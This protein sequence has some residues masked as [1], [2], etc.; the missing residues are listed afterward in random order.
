MAVPNNIHMAGWFMDS[1]R[2]GQMGLSII[3]GHVDGRRET[4]IFNAS[5]VSEKMTN[6]LSNGRWQSQVLP[7]QESGDCGYR[8]DNRRFIFPRPENKE[9]D[10]SHICGSTFNRQAR[11]YDKRVI[12][13]SELIRSF[14]CRDTAVIELL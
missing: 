10:E 11:Q 3:D 7:G 14:N 8:G 6:I 12:A 1:V 2:P 5:P 9:P 4:A 13:I